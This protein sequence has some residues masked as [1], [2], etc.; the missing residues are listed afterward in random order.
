[1]KKLLVVLLWAAIVYGQ[2]AGVSYLPAKQA[3]YYYK[4]ADGSTFES[5]MSITP[6]S[7]FKVTVLSQD[8][9]YEYRKNPG[10]VL[11]SASPV[12][13]AEDSK[14]LYFKGEYG[15]KIPGIKYP[16]KKAAL[17]SYDYSE[18]QGSGAFATTEKHKTKF[19][20]V[21]TDE[22][23]TTPAGVFKHVVIV[24]TGEVIFFYA[25]NVGLIRKDIDDK[26]FATLEKITVTYSTK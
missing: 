16:V 17:W 13:L 4:Y 15:V 11:G 9:Y 22:E 7:E 5:T 14:G 2:N 26:P 12:Y 20:I 1:M 19:K 10:E 24:N 18:T 3:V 23:I 25:P 8:L 6:A 21:A